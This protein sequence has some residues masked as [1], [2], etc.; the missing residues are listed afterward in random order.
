MLGFLATFTFIE[1]LFTVS[2]C[3]G[4]LFFVLRTISLLLGAFGN[5]GGANADLDGDGVPDALEQGGMADLDGDGIPDSLE[6][7]GMADLD[8]DGIPDALES[9]GMADL[10]GDGIPDA[11]EHGEMVD[12]DG[13]GIPDVLENSTHGDSLSEHGLIEKVPLLKKFISMQ[14]LS[15]FFMMFGLI[16]LAMMRS[17]GF[18]AFPS[19]LAGIAGGIFSAWILIKM[20]DALMKLVCCGNA[21]TVTAIGKVG[22]V[23]LH[24]PSNGSGQVE[25][26]VDGRL[27]ILD[28]VSIDNAEIKTDIEVLVIDIKKDKDGLETL[29]VKPYF[30][31]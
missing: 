14:N 6:S 19:V 20:T 2:A 15:M 22:R 1:K 31:Q 12:I 26:E 21:R 27:K 11:L 18:S 10:D 7:G 13:D 17:S 16:G 3:L 24:I 4:S 29:V 23:Y 28:A 25:V 9:G 8:G 5:S 30:K